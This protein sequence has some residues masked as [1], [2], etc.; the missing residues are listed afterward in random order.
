[1]LQR[2]RISFSAIHH[3]PRSSISQ[4]LQYYHVRVVQVACGGRHTVVVTENG[5]TFSAGSN[6]FGQ[7]GQGKEEELAEEAGDGGSAAGDSASDS[8][9]GSEDGD[10]ATVSTV[11][12]SA[13]VSSVKSEFMARG[14]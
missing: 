3:P 10:G 7:L 8:K 2:Q 9:A 14:R 13:T 4:I 6:E 1:V 12:D 11:K 5:E